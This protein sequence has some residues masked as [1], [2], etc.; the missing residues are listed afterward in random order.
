MKEEEVEFEQL[1]KNNRLVLKITLRPL[2][3]QNKEGLFFIF[4]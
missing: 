4:F 2:K 1:A 3:D